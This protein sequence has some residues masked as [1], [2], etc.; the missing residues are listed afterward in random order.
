MRM[1]FLIAACLTIAAGAAVAEVY[2]SFN[3]G[4]RFEYPA[5]W[6]YSATGDNEVLFSKDDGDS[7][8]VT[9][10]RYILEEGFQI[11]SEDELYVA[12]AG[13]YSAMGM[14]PVDP[15]EVTYRKA[16]AMIVFEKRYNQSAASGRMQYEK[17]VK[18]VLCRV[19]DV[20]Q[21]LY[22]IQ[23]RVP[24]ESAVLYRSD[25]NQTVSSFRITLDLA[26]DV[27]PADNASKYLYILIILL[28][29]AFFFARNRRVQR[30]KNPLGRDSSSFWRCRTCS[31]VNHIEHPHCQR[32]GAERVI[33]ATK[34]D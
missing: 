24:F 2:E 32:C 20:G 14:P 5:G 18:G 23:T 7:V 4:F 33:I 8:A 13:L 6:I 17:I 31:R 26:D 11:G 28:L 16:D 12:I 29:T 34:K 21:T 22:L 15:E 10:T 19:P 3:L 1:L 25:I 30:S 9:V 27:F